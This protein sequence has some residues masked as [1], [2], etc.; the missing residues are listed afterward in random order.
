[1]SAEFARP[2]PLRQDAPHRTLGGMPTGTRSRVTRLP[3]QRIVAGGTPAPT[4]LEA[5][6]AELAAALREEIEASLEAPRAPQLL[7]IP[8]AARR[9]GVSRT[10]I[11]S[12][13]ASGELRSV[14]V[15]RRRLVPEHE[16][17]TLSHGTAAGDL[18]TP[19]AEEVSGAG[20]DDPSA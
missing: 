4:R 7:S 13:I 6:I 2:D 12:L 5:A 17:A 3:V 20:H 10:L 9:A 15:G 16:L 11:Y 1:M 19:A 8:D 14:K 18:A